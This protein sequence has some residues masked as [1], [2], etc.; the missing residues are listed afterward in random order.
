MQD[1]ERTNNAH[2]FMTMQQMKKKMHTFH[3]NAAQIRKEQIIHVLRKYIH[4]SAPAKT[5]LSGCAC[6][7]NKKE[8]SDQNIIKLDNNAPSKDSD[9]PVF[10]CSLL[11]VFDETQYKI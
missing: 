1:F 10:K 3:D 5:Q 4:S 11:R 6:L 8:N 7:Y 2:V 9:Q